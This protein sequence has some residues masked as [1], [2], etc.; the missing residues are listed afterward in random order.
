[1]KTLP[2]GGLSSNEARERLA[3]FG[4]NTFGRRRISAGAVLLRQLRN[5]LLLV[6]VATAIVSSFLGDRV[7]A[8]IILGIIALS[9]GLGFFNEYR[10]EKA[11]EDL[12][13][14]V[15]HRAIVMRDGALV[16][17]DVAS[18]VPGDLVSLALGDIVPADL[19]LIETHDLSCGESVLTGEAVAVEKKA[20]DAAFMGT[21]VESGKGEG[22]VVKTG[23]A[24][25]FGKIA[26]HLADRAPQTAFEIGLRSFSQMLVTVTIVLTGSIFALNALLHHPL[27][28]SLLFALAIAVGLTPQLLPAIVTV[29]LATG[30]RRLAKKQ[31][32]VKRLVSI[33]DFGNVEVL[34][35]DKTGTLTEGALR[36]ERAVDLADGVSD[37]VLAL[38]LACNDVVVHDGTI[39]GGTSLD[40]ALWTAALERKVTPPGA[41]RVADVPFDYERKRM[42]VLVDDGAGRTLITKGAPESVLACC[43][44]VPENARNALSRYFAAGARVIAVASRELPNAVD[45]RVEDERELTLQGFLLFDDPPKASAAR[46]I[47]RL[48][49]LGIQIRIVTGDNEQVAAKVCRDLG[50]RVDAILT[51]AELEALSDAELQMRI[52]STTIFARVAPDQKSRII[53]LQRELGVDVGFL[54][55]G[56]NDAVALHYADVGISVD[57]ATDVAKDAADIILLDKDL[58]IL[59]DGVVEGRRIFSNTI[60]YVLMGTS[61]NFGNMFSAAGA[62]LFL[63]FLPMTASQILLNNLLY[64]VSEMAI[65]TDRVDEA[66]LRRP[67]HWDVTFIRRFMIVFGPISSIFDFLT[68]AVMLFVFHAGAAL[69]QSGWFVE[70]LATQSLII[71]VIRTRQVPFFRS[72]ASAP[73]TVTTLAVVALGALLPFSPVGRVIGFVP[74]P[75]LFFGILIV[76]VVS[77]LALVELAKSLFY[78]PPAVQRQREARRELRLRRVASRWIH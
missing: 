63:P 69:F 35:T 44:D 57:S 16:D 77:Y 52:P 53:R 38:A 8:A 31:V 76:M 4:S 14:R 9:V 54:G 29:S 68:F 78:R 45:A 61:S 41:A 43:V 7:N 60:K 48:R 55:D 34:F 46:S 5:P 72:R 23:A 1:M 11:M 71:F 25:A 66:M 32:I 73:L 6:L 19:S 3:R 15:A 2:A 28:E 24:T 74:L 42:S 70:S 37:E 39:G 30:A 27:F 13:R 56:V 64:D 10:S 51:G 20:G 12:H 21:T 67:S 49:R 26:A 59:A 33:E 75:P 47:E 50:I 17:V 62:S 40:R 36:F 58:A 22:V 18:L 65:P